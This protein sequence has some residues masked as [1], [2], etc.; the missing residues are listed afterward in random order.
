MA[1]DE[2]DISILIRL[3]NKFSAP[4]KDV[5]KSSDDISEGLDNISTKGK[6]AATAIVAAAAKIKQKFGPAADAIKTSTDGIGAGMKDAEEKSTAASKGMGAALTKLKS[7]SKTVAQAVGTSFSVLGSKLRSVFRGIVGGIKTI[8]K[9]LFSLKAL[10][11]ALLSGVLIRRITQ[12]ADAWQDLTNRLAGFIESGEKVAVVQQRLFEIAQRTK[13]PINSIA[14]IFQRL[15]IIQDDLGK[16]TNEL[17]FFI[18]SLSKAVVISGATATESSAA[19][20]QLSQGM[21]TGTLRAQDLKSVMS[22]LPFVA[23]VI[24]EE[25]GITL[26]ELRALGEQGKIT[27]EIIFDAF[28]NRAADIEKRVLRTRVTIGASLTALTNSFTRFVGIL[29]TASGAFD[30]ITGGILFVSKL[31]DNMTTIVTNARKELELI[32]ATMI[33]FGSGVPGGEILETGP[34]KNTAIGFLLAAVREAFVEIGRN[35]LTIAVNMPILILGSFIEGIIKFVPILID[36]VKEIAKVFVTEIVKVFQE[37]APKV[38]SFL[39]VESAE[40]TFNTG[41]L[42]ADLESLGGSLR[43]QG[44]E[45]ISQSFLNIKDALVQF[46]DTVNE[47]ATAVDELNEKTQTN[48]DLNDAN[49]EAI[50]A[51]EEA[52]KA[53]K[54]GFT[55]AS[56]AVVDSIDEFKDLGAGIGATIGQ[57][58][59]DVGTALSDIVVNSKNAKEAFRNLAVSM[60]T[61]IATLIIQFLILRAISAFFPGFGGFLGIAAAAAHTGGKIGD[62]QKA[63]GFS[64]GGHVSGPPPATPTTDNVPALLQ[65]DEWVIN[66][67]AA[68]YYTDRGMDAINRMLVPREALGSL[69][70]T[71]KQGAQAQYRFAGGGAVSSGDTEDQAGPA[72]AVVA[73]SEANVRNLLA[74]GSNAIFAFVRENSDQLNSMINKRA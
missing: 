25:L 32:R 70:S 35:L 1:A 72:I 20:L 49:T 4:A 53:F 8:L 28:T 73:P 17:L 42:V 46:G 6:S 3:R 66:A 15:L 44:F 36:I 61:Q 30:K 39:G 45:N 60:L 64:G 26:G 14:T 18:E 51:M 59:L 55:A 62:L 65:N 31:L 69:G 47:V 74:G 40:T 56:A 5:S 37:T 38:A 12:L 21:A 22:Q 29:V 63:Q 57:G 41:G 48:I 50:G 9:S 33:D 54:E 24:A 43:A 58:L 2:K 67:R 52:W 13:Q 19:L 10:I 27:T 23:Q 68:R 16:S 11:F 7:T 71:V 34:Q